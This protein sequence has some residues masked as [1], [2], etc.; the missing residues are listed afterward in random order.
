MET[1]PYL[2]IVR[3]IIQGAIKQYEAKFEDG[4]NL[5]WGDMDSG[6]S[7]ILNLIDYCL[8]GKN[9]D[10][11]YG[12]MRANARIAH[13]EVDLNGKI[14]T[15]ERDVL[16]EK[17]PIRVYTGY[18]EQRDRNFPLMMAATA[19]DNSAPDGWI[20]DFILDNLGIAKVSIRESRFRENADSDRLSF[21]DLMKLMYLKQSRVGS[22]ALLNYQSPV[23]F[24]K[25]VE[26][27]KFVFNVYDDELSA[28]NSE[29]SREIVEYNELEKN[30]R[31]IKK[32]LN[33][34]KIDVDGFDKVVGEAE[35]YQNKIAELDASLAE[36]KNDFVLSTDI[37]ATI[38][39]AIKDMRTEMSRIDRSMNEIESQYNN[40][41]KLSNTYR[42]D[43]D[44]LKLSKVSRSIMSVK[45]A[46]NENIA[47]PL[48]QSKVE[49]TSPSVA[50]EDID[51]Q[52]KSLK[53]R[54][55]GIGSILSDL[56][57]KQRSLTLRKEQIGASLNDASRSFDENQASSI[58]PLLTSIQAIEDSRSQL[59]VVLAEAERNLAIFNK[60]S[61]I[62]S[63]IEVK[64][65]LIEKLRRAI[66]ITKDGLIGID[67]VIEELT[68]LF[69]A[70]MH[71]S[72]LQKVHGVYLDKKFVAHFRD[73]SYYNTSSGGVRTITSIALFVT[74][75]Q[76]LLKH[77]CNLPTF[78]MIDTPGQNI[79][80][81]RTED[82]NTEVSDPK[83]YEKIFSQIMSVVA[84]A[85]EKGRRCQVIVVDN[86]LPDSLKS[87]K[88]FH[89]VKRFSKQGGKFE[90]GLINDA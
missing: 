81:F 75:L 54:N 35:D 71:K 83:L 61:D 46:Q 51:Y 36:L 39:A 64:S 47:C 62:G 25:N 20:S 9:S 74:R 7:S 29:L 57:E 88:N 50:D 63:K 86:D 44:A 1:S 56:R 14:Y 22:D 38:S 16:S 55:A 13:L 41:A 52:L 90:K 21:R 32:F 60:Y 24:N 3:L 48:C 42:F 53:N 45:R 33:D 17:S 66:K 34:V 78:L 68:S 5:I 31:F 43:H 19:S 23:V 65:V 49:I 58:S 82:D 67:S 6:K 28:L 10:F 40:Y 4:L 11:L 72:G 2:V 37:G 18:Y 85:A 77:A 87:G 69:A 73:I 79:G 30:E 26:I 76:Y 59:K 15:F 80:R 27:Q 84:V 89:L 70:H 8:G 12:E